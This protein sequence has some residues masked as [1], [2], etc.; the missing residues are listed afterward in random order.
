MIRF[1]QAKD[2]DRE[3]PSAPVIAR[4]ATEAERA[5]FGIKPARDVPAPDDQA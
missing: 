5:R 2:Y 3:L 4:Q 1:Q